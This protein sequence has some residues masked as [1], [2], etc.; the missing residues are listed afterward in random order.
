MDK[1]L[2]AKIKVLIKSYLLQ[3]SNG[4]SATR[5]AALINRHRWGFSKDVD[6]KLV[7][8]VIRTSRRG[9]DFLN[10]I[11]HK[12]V[13]G[14][15]VYYITDD[16]AVKQQQVYHP[17]LFDRFGGRE[18]IIQK[19]NEGYTQNKL[20]IEMGCTPAVIHYYCK[21]N[22]IDWLEVKRGFKNEK[23]KNNN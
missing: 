22:D 19:I 13:D 15:K 11:Q 16:N 21:K 5:I 8:Y 3:Y 7:N 10:C 2:R 17:H 18:Y 6:A 4:L 20:A 9:G 1:L 14:K 23:I 12:L